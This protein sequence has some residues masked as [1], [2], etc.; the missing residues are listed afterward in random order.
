MRL[1]LV[2][3]LTSCS[4][5]EPVVEISGSSSATDVVKGSITVDGKPATLGACK[6][7]HTVH[8]FVEVVTNLGKLRFEEQQL[9]WNPIADAPTRGD[10]LACDK[11]DRSWGGGV[12]MPGDGTA[13][14]RGTLAFSCGAIAGDL[15]LDCGNIT[16]TERAQLD[17][18]R[19]ELQDDQRGSK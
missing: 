15:T 14:W 4:K 11:L 8:V 9:Y 1:L 3:A 13:Y 10:K 7:G 6:P 18:K 17:G 5:D 19:K 12:R 16:P 2:L